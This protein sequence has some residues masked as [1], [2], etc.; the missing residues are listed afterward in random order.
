MVGGGVLTLKHPLVH[1]RIRIADLEPRTELW[2][3][4]VVVIFPETYRFLDR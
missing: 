4:L 1:V 2:D 3:R